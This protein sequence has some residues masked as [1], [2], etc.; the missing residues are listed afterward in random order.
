MASVAQT[1]EPDKF[2]EDGR[3]IAASLTQYFGKDSVVLDFGCG[4]GRVAKYIAPHWKELWCADTSARMLKL[5]S[6]S[7]RGLEN[8]RFVRKGV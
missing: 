4:I 6:E 5:A 8:V 1:T 3:A 2:W 7:L